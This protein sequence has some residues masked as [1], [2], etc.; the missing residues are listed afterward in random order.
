[1]KLHLDRQ[2][3]S[4]GYIYFQSIEEWQNIYKTVQWKIIWKTSTNIQTMLEIII[5]VTGG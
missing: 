1:M 2:G 5:N 3:F 4:F